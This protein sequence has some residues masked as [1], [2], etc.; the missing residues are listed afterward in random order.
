[1][2]CC[3]AAERR[4]GLEPRRPATDDAASLVI[5]IAANGPQPS[6]ERNGW[7]RESGFMICR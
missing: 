3:R 1:M 4:P 6:R 5:L 2:E 7:S